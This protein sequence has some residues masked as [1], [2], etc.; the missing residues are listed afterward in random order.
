LP[1][2]PGDMGDTADV[3][4]RSPL[5]TRMLLLRNTTLASDSLTPMSPE[6]RERSRLT[7]KLKT[8]GTGVV[9]N[10]TTGRRE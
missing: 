8:K 2:C 6:M 10:R 3:I 5:A 9:L 1:P 4:V 7:M